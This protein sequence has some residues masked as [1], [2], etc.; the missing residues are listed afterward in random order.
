MNG[1]T[2]ENQASRDEPTP[3]AEGLAAELLWA[4]E[5]K[6]WVVAI[7]MNADD[8]SG[9]SD[10]ADDF[11]VAVE[12]A[13]KAHL[14]FQKYG[15]WENT[16]G[17]RAMEKK[18]KDKLLL[19]HN[20]GKILEKFPRKDRK[21]VEKLYNKSVEEHRQRRLGVSGRDVEW[22]NFR[23]FIEWVSHHAVH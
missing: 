7:V 11:G 14:V 21:A 20:A 9:P 6:A 17:R 4:A 3:Q 16:A 15:P 22:P 19:G 12:M 13:L 1:P 10:I 23:D 2:R 8:D 5:T 18:L